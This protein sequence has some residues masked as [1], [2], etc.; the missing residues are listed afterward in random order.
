[1]MK[2]GL[3]N[4]HFLF[5]PL[6]VTFLLLTDFKNSANGWG[7]LALS[8]AGLGGLYSV[9]DHFSEGII[10]KLTDPNLISKDVLVYIFVK[11]PLCLFPVALLM[12]AIH[13]SHY[14][15]NLVRPI[16]SWTII[17]FSIP[18]VVMYFV[19]LNPKD[20]SSLRQF[21]IITNLW[22]F[23]YTAM[24]YY[25]LLQSVVSGNRRF[26]KDRLLTIITIVV[27]T[28]IYVSAVYL[29][30]LYHFPI[31][32]FNPYLVIIFIGLF[33]FL[34]L[35]YGFLGFKLSIRNLDLDNAIETVD[36]ELSVLN[37]HIKDKILQIM[38][39]A[40]EIDTAV[41]GDR[42]SVVKNAETILAAAEGISSVSE[43]LHRYLD[44]VQL[45]PILQNITEVVKEALAYFES[46]I[47]E[48]ALRID[49]NLSQN[50]I[51][52]FD[53]FYLGEVLKKI[54]QNSVEAMEAGD[55]IIIDAL[56]SKRDVTLM[57]TDT[58]CGISSKDL[59]H[60]IKPFY[61]T[62]DPKSHFGL[63]LPYCYNI[64]R[65]HGGRLEIESVEDKGTT[66]FLKFP[67]KNITY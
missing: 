64:M 10:E 3:M 21:L 43:Q 49:N 15:D 52:K 36:S 29:L 32:M 13:Y 57:I 14:N 62:K 44:R 25:F 53:R 11:T 17:L 1:M 31:F 16:K 60:I 28:A 39:C 40:Q 65:Q 46:R 2:E 42:D 22:S 4:I 9:V 51:L 63:G 61:T 20:Y 38:A 5:L 18:A 50:L 8:F 30:P 41:E 23:P 59:P 33:S 19:P 26:E 54:L 6:F 45:N 7:S 47:Q 55:S 12:F 67:I 58:G 48:K 37:Y 66:V 24:T 27:I 35:K 56:R 34:L